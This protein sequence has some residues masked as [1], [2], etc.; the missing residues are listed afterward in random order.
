MTY[1]TKRQRQRQR[2]WQIHLENT[3]RAIVETFDL[4]T[5]VMR[6]RDLTNKNTKTLREQLIIILEKL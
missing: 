3:L 2:Q 1:P 4:S 5:R 6:K